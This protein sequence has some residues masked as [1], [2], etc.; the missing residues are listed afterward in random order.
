MRNF[1]ECSVNSGSELLWLEER[2][3]SLMARTGHVMVLVSASGNLQVDLNW[4]VLEALMQI[5]RWW[6]AMVMSRLRRWVV[7]S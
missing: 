7:G 2:R 4:S 6:E 1:P 5:V 3:N